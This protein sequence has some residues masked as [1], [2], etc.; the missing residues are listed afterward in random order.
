M[1]HAALIHFVSFV[2]DWQANTLHVYGMNVQ[3]ILT[4][5]PHEE[6]I[7]PTVVQNGGDCLLYLIR[8]R[9]GPCRK[10]KRSYLKTKLQIKTNVLK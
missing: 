10:I 9:S 7:S 1:S 2:P 5:L 8:R 4:P 3:I 6:Q